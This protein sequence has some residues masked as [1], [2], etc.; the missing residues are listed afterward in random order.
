MDLVSSLLTLPATTALSWLIAAYLRH[1]EFS[2]LALKRRSWIVKFF[3]V[4]GI[5]IRM[6]LGLPDPD[7]LLKRYGSGSF[8]FL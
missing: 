3:A 1:T 5:L 8:T 2:T 6:F 7:P 4:M